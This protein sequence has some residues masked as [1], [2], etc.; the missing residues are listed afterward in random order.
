MRK[1]LIVAP[2]I[3]WFVIALDI[4][5]DVNNIIPTSVF[6]IILFTM[7]TVYMILFIYANSDAYK[8][9]RDNSGN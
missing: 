8:E 4:A 3:I 1:F 2:V 9:I 6:E 5:S 7:L